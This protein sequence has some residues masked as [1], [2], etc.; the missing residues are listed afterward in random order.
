MSDRV[1]VFNEGVI[2]QIDR[3]DQLYEAPVNRFVA[4]F[5]G[6]NSVLRA[7]VARS[8]ADTCE[9]EL[10]DGTR[11]QGLNV[12]KA[13]AGDA[14]LCSIRPER[15]AVV[16]AAHTAGNLVAAAVADVIYFGD[17]L[18]LRCQ[19]PDQPEMSVKVPLEHLGRMQAGQSVHLHLPANH[20]RV[21]R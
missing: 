21:Y 1:A 13:Q 3:V 16:D 19:I 20:M 18:R 11:L 5:V 17:H 9:V 6:D 12:N 10:A 2:Q 14:V 15:I 7:R 8:D 4:S